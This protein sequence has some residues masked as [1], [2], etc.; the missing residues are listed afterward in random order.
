M[1]PNKLVLHLSDILN[2]DESFNE[3]LDQ[4]MIEH[5]PQLN[6][7]RFEEDPNE[8]SKYY[9]LRNEEFQRVM[10]EVLANQKLNKAH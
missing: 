5:H 8:E 3:H 7:E 2:D 10:S 9:E 6:P 1:V 4:F